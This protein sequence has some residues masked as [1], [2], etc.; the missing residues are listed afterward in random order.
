[1]HLKGHLQ[2]WI[3]ILLILSMNTTYAMTLAPAPLEQ[4]IEEAELVVRG[5]IVQQRPEAAPDQ[6]GQL[7]TR[8]LLWVWEH[9]KA[10]SLDAGVA[11]SGWLEFVQP[12]GSSAHL[13][14]RVPGVPIFQAGDEVVLLLA[15]T[16][17]GLQP[18][19]YPLG[20]FFITPKGSIEPAWH[21]H[22]PA[23]LL[24]LFP[25]DFWRHIPGRGPGG[26]AP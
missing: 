21:G 16:P 24:M 17:W 19:G 15:H 10:P 1:M 5:V 23:D 11:A 9:L 8:Y 25:P 22:K 14:T 18:L 2:A 13:M 6:P 20:T 12:G 26:I 4:L 3:A 7:R